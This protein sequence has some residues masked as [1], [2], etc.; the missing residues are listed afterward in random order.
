MKR[1]GLIWFAISAS[2]ADDVWC[3]RRNSGDGARDVS[4]SGMLGLV[5]CWQALL[6]RARISAVRSL[7]GGNAEVHIIFTTHAL[8]LMPP[9]GAQTAHYPLLRITRFENASSLRRPNSIY[10]LLIHRQLPPRRRFEIPKFI[11]SA[12]EIH[13]PR[14][15]TTITTNQVA[16]GAPPNFTLREQP[17]SVPMPDNAGARHHPLGLFRFVRLHSRRASHHVR[18]RPPKLFGILRA[19]NKPSAEKSFWRHAPH[20][21]PDALLQLSHRCRLNRLHI[22]QSHKLPS[23]KRS[24]IDFDSDFHA[25][26]FRADWGRN[27]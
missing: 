4:Y 10:K 16:R 18:Q 6:R 14:L 7:S 27:C 11:R 25:E 22:R 23:L 8:N 17:K 20:F 26:T 19:F 1:P 2:S 9:P 21:C 12:S 3:R 5:R 15:I 24:T 13:C